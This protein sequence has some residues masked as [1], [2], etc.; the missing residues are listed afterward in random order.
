[1][2]LPIDLFLVRHGESEGNI[3]HKRDRAG[4]SS[5]LTDEHRARHSSTYRLTDRGIEQARA[6]GAWI[7]NN[8]EGSFDHFLTSPFLRARETAAH[9]NLPG[10]AWEMDPYLVERDHGELDGLSQAE[11]LEKFGAGRLQ[12]ML[13][14]F[15]RKAPNGE[16]RLDIGLRWDRIM[17]SLSQRHPEHRVVI[18][19]HETIIESGLIRRLHWTIE[20]F[21]EWKERNDP[22]EKVNNCQVIHFS[23]RNPETGQVIDKVR[24]WRSACPWDLSLANGGWQ[25]INARRFTSSELLEQVERHP[26]LINV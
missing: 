12:E 5:L 10:A 6:A 18:V 23:R 11:R 14:S 8:F 26:R 13:H 22:R 15:Y 25:Q 3:A 24:W 1:M 9:M 16:S 7:R 2:P 21:Y 20:E 17:L 19:A 4:D